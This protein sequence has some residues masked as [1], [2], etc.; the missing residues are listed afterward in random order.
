MRD[1]FLAPVSARRV[2][3]RICGNLHRIYLQLEF[4]EEATRLQRY[5]VA[6]SK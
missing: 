3:V 4:A 2:L 1:D 6:L 5:L